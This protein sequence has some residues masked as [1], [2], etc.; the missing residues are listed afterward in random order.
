MRYLLH[1]S[2]KECI[3]R[4]T[5]KC[6][7]MRFWLTCA[8]YWNFQ[9]V[10][11][12]VEKQRIFILVAYSYGSLVAIEL[13][14]RLENQGLNGRLVL[15]DGAPD[16]MKAMIEQHLPYQTQEELQNN[17]LLYVMDSLQPAASGKVDFY[18]WPLKYFR[19]SPNFLVLIN[20]YFYFAATF[21]FE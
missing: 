6:L 4:Y 15:I 7:S 9:Y 18:R 20:I 10:L 8:L 1:I 13:A 2:L 16:L 14:R 12:K 21:R 5:E 3:V 17:I 11:P 19:S